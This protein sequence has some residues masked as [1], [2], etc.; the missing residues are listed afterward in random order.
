MKPSAR[1]DRRGGWVTCW[2]TPSLILLVSF[3]L[4]LFRLGDGNLW[5]DEAL[6]VWAVRKGFFGATL[7][8]AGDVH[9]P[10]YFWSL[11]AWTQFAGE[12]EF[13]IRALSAALGVLSVAAVYSLGRLIGGRAVGGLGALLTGLSRFHVWWSQE[14]RMYMLAGLMGVLSLYFFVRWIRRESPCPPSGRID[15]CPPSLLLAFYVLAS[16]GA[17][18]SVLLMGA[19]VLAENVVVLTARFCW[20]GRRRALLRK[21]TLAQAAILFGM[22]PW[23]ALSWGR[24][25]TWSQGEPVR[26]GFLARLYATLLTAGISVDVEQYTWALLL[27]AAVLAIGGLLFFVEHQRG[28]PN[29]PRSIALLTLAL[30]SVIPPLVIYLT[31]LPRSLFYTP[32]LEA[33]YF[34]PFAPAFWVL[35][36]CSVSQ[37][38]M[39]WRTVAWACGIGLLALWVGFLPGYYASRHLRDELQT[40]VRAIVSQAERGDAVLLDS[41][42]RYPLFLYYYERLGD[43]SL[44]PPML[45]VTREEAPLTAEEVSG[46]MQ[47]HLSD[48]SRI[49]LA[50]V[51]ANLTDPEH[52]VE[53]QL[54]E[55]LEKV[56]SERYG[57]NALHLYD[58]TARPPSLTSN[59]YTPQHPLDASVGRGGYLAGWEL[60]VRRFVPG[61]TI[62]V[63]LLWGRLPDG[64]VSVSL[65]NPQDQM[66]IERHMGPG[67]VRDHQ[68]QQFDLPVSASTPAGR[69]TLRLLPPLP[70]GPV[71]GALYT[72]RTA[73]WP[74]VGPPEAILDVRLGESIV[75]EGYA[76]KRANGENPDYLTPE[77]NLIVD[78]YWRAEQAPQRYYTVFVHLLG[79]AFNPSTQGAVWGQHD[80]PPVDGELP[81][82]RWVEG[83]RMVDRHVIAVGEGAPAGDYRI[84]LGMYGSDDGERLSITSKDGRPLGDHVLLDEVVRVREN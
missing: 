27:P 28:H 45:T 78:L 65:W 19:L 84:E 42:G 3:G 23:L 79:E 70:K 76:L 63:S 44:R 57:Y 60:P 46:W 14:T 29:R 16:L 26:L 4:R 41:G 39:R 13:A 6:A 52:Y 12:S 36:A 66:V 20:R 15:R 1:A 61:D 11:W 24:M 83:D 31:L 72:E 67:A 77:G 59:G 64:P 7:W 38:G 43:G 37:I 9:P 56:L 21:W 54:S 81:T 32:R 25:S 71:L 2:G 30:A 48:Y 40:M 73:P 62:R 5:W 22:S 75:L 8:T 10:L 53:K 18:Y 68:R 33:R 69:Y 51:D 47:T 34:L 50:E 55:R 58:A 80:G 82:D 49:W 17:L 74:Q 35:L